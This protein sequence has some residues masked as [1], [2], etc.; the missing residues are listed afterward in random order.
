MFNA[1]TMVAVKTTAQL[2]TEQNRVLTINNPASPLGLFVDSYN[3]DETATRALPTEVELV[4]AEEHFEEINDV[5]LTEF[6]S[7]ENNQIIEEIAY[8]VGVIQFNTRNVIVPSIA[9]MA[10]NYADRQ[11]NAASFIKDVDTYN[12]D[13]I[14]DKPEMTAHLERYAGLSPLPN[15]RT[16]LLATPS[17]P[18]II[19]MATENN[20]NLDQEE[21]LNWALKMSPDAILDVWNAL[22]TVSRNFSPNAVKW[23]RSYNPAETL[24]KMTLGYFL[25]AYMTDNPQEVQGEEV[26]EEAWTESM[27]LLHEAFGKFLYEMHVAR[28][29][30]R[31][32]GLLVLNADI[33]NPIQTRVVRVLLNGDVARDW[34]DAGNDVQ[35]ILGAL[36]ISRALNNVTDIEA[37]SSEYIAKWRELYPTIEQAAHDYAD[38][39]ARQQLQEAFLEEAEKIEAFDLNLIPEVRGRVFDL[40]RSLYPEDLKNPY[41]SFGMLICQLFYTDPVYWDY[42]CY[43]EQEQKRYPDATARELST[44]ALITI[45]SIWV[46]RQFSVT[47]YQADI[48]VVI[49]IPVEEEEAYVDPTGPEVAADV[50][51]AITDPA[52]VTP[53]TME[54]SDA[55]SQQVRAQQDEA[56]A[57]SLGIDPDTGAVAV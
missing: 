4:S 38:R 19:K 42:L 44:Q 34:L 52:E 47:P 23:V 45:V 22:F 46:A 10:Q 2:L 31:Q 39:I 50:E 20:P 11:S 51:A 1:E 53:S 28:A 33:E 15:Y 25:A 8:G 54:E 27:R 13:P 49:D 24:D 9:A 30:V 37:N 26:G 18:E 12:Y 17:V 14:H 32:N 57:A 3:V 40:T 16:F 36:S 48:G 5:E 41:H 6:R 7:T 35:A 56:R 43:I 55:F 21:A 29:D